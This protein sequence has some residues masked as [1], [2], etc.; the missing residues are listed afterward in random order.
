MVANPGNASVSI[1]GRTESAVL[2]VASGIT[3]LTA[4]PGQI[5][6]GGTTPVTITAALTTVTDPGLVTFTSGDADLRFGNSA[7][8]TPTTGGAVALCVVSS[9][10][11]TLPMVIADNTV[12]RS[13]PI[14][15][16]DAGGRALTLAP[17]QV[18]PAA[19][20]LT[21]SELTT[22]EPLVAGGGGI[23]EPD[24]DEHRRAGL[25]RSTDHRVAADRHHRRRHHQPDRRRRDLH[26]TA[27][28][29]CGRWR[30]ER[31]TR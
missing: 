20:A 9:G 31:R 1:D 24:G 12:T 11:A 5:T 23:A 28:A 19:P 15:V 22:T 7:T 14:S 8:C 4:N 17:I 10:T 30:P 26:S 2:Q 16:A 18:V 27:P 3:A 21:L 25:R 13:V 29:G 6:A